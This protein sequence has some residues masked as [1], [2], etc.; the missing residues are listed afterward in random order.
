[1]TKVV[2]EFTI[3]LDGFIAGPD[4]DIRPIFGWYYAGDTPY[5]VPGSGMV[6]NVSKAS[7]DL[8]QR[9]WGSVGA[10]VT[11]RR[12]FDVSKA[13]G[14]KPP[15]AVPT[16]IITHHPP[17]EWSYAG[18]PFIFVTEGVAAALEQAKAAAAGKDI[19]LGG[20][21]IVQQALQ[22]GLV[23]EIKLHL[24]PVLLGAGIR[25]FDQLNDQTIALEIKD[26]IEG[27]GVT[28]LRYR[29]VK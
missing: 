28:H 2:T 3:S 25:L 27:T 24:A 7:A 8:L 23:D 9:D 1:M 20:T 11:G 26:V 19:A 13:W 21:K 5:R 29:V 17:Q 12:D 10:I 14:G 22:A 16:F 18:S 6:F 4:D 15:L